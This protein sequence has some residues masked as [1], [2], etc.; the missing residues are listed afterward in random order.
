MFHGVGVL[1]DS[2]AELDCTVFGIPAPD[3]HWEMNGT[4]LSSGAQYSIT[5]LPTTPRYSRQILTITGVFLD[6]AARYVCVATNRAGMDTASIDLEVL[7]MCECVCMCVC[8]CVCV[9][10]CACV[11]VCVCVCVCVCA[12]MC[13]CVCM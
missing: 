4:Q 2:V 12:C 7:G 13:M 11:R 9:C 1:I 6:D 10:V 5:I 3:L 8:V